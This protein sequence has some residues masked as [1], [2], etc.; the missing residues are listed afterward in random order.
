MVAFVVGLSR[1]NRRKGEMIM[2]KGSNLY[3]KE[4]W[5]IKDLLSRGYSTKKISKQTGRAPGTIA[6]IRRSKNYPNYKFRVSQWGK[7]NDDKASSPKVEQSSE[8]DS[9]SPTR[10][11]YGCILL[12]IG[13][14]CV[15]AIVIT[16]ITVF[17]GK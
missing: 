6:T 13:L 16:S 3:E 14:I 10:T 9:H 12:S 11:L 4:Y 5:E 7:R 8:L 2:S 17:W 1:N 15:T